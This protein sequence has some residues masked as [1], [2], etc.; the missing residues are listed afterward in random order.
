MQFHAICSKW[1]Q[2]LTLSLS[3]QNIEEARNILHGQGYSIM[4][5]KESVEVKNNQISWSNFFYFDVLIN[6]QLKSWK[7][8][9]EDIFKSYKKLVEDLKYNVVYIYTNEWMPEEQKKTIT[10]KVKDSYRMYKASM[11]ENIDDMR[12][13]T[14]DE[15]DIHQIS[16]QILREIEKYVLIIDSTVEKIQN[17]FLK[18]HTTVTP[19]KK[20]E[21]ESLEQNLLQAKGSSNL[22]KIKSITEHALTVIGQIEL[23][24]AKTG[25]NTEKQQLLEETNSLLKQIGSSERM[26]IV[27]KNDIDIGKT[28]SNF[29]AKIKKTSEE[30]KKTE[31]KKVDTNSFI[32]YKNQRELNLY[33]ENLNKNDIQIVKAILTFHFWK[34]KRLLLKKKLLSQNIQIIDNRIHNRNISYTKIVHGFQ[35]YVDMFLSG[36]NQ[37]ATIFTYTLFVYLIIYIGLNIGKNYDLLV[38]SYQPKAFLFITIFALSTLILSF[39]KSMKAFFIG[40][41]LMILMIIFFSVNF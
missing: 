20:I 2:K 27:K 41:I 28:F 7:I 32:Y 3:A 33:K 30:P 15:Y 37:I 11:G 31:W 39:I 16:P 17:L 40:S 5:I 21:L 9:S 10:A 22:G 6:N 19:E 12:V 38:Y 8:Q 14:Q 36:I 26:E 13:Q 34:I 25:M 4:E 1:N 35:Y 18:Y 23:E 24:L 29:F